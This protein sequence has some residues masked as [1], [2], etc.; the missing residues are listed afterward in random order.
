MSVLKRWHDLTKPAA[1]SSAD[2]LSR[3]INGDNKKVSKELKKSI[4]F[5]THRDLRENFK[6]RRNFATYPNE[7]WEADLADFGG[8]IPKELTGDKRVGRRKQLQMLVVVD[9]FSRAIYAVGLKNKES[10]EVVSGM[11]T[12]FGM[13]GAKPKY[14]E[15]DDGGEFKSKIFKK[16]CE[17]ENI[18]IHVSLQKNKARNSERAIRSLKRVIM[19]SVQTD[20][21]PKNTTWT[22][23]PKIAAESLNK[24]YNRDIKT[25]P[26]NLLNSISLIKK[27]NQNQWN[28]SNSEPLGMY[29]D[30]EKLLQ[31]GGKIIENG[32]K[33][34]IGDL[35]LKMIPKKRRAEVK[36]K[37]YMMHYS[38][39]PYK[40]VNIYH[41][42]LPRLYE[43]LQ[44]ATN[45][46][47][48]RL[49]YSKEFK[50][51][52]LPNNIV[53]EDIVDY[54]VVSGKISFKN[55]RGDWLTP[56]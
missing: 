24:R 35:V 32:M 52:E 53:P 8:R 56:I 25:T 54:K 27:E 12:I 55:K 37:E 43:L 49:F 29:D 39:I 13:V 15:T 5:Q 23:I 6:R 31:S 36:D 10:K 42:R 44:P 7:R 41:E 47:L 1:F 40:I 22:E 2:Y 33:L 3:A 18:Q 48:K 51:I 45:K 14:L 28:E 21:W 9:V 16:M 19:G 30:E 26:Q 50:K 38:P 4:L 20:T 46:K 34:G 11:K 17:E